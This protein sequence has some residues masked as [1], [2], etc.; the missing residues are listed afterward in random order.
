MLSIRDEGGLAAV[1]LKRLLQKIFA[2]CF[3]E[4]FD[5]FAYVLRALT[6]TDEQR[7]GSFHYDQ[8]L[9]ADRSDEFLRAVKEIAFSVDRLPAAVVRKNIFA[10][11]LCQQFI[12][13]RPGADIA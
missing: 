8:I 6:W 4:L 7:V 11:T 1:R 3:F 5:D 13:C 2:L 9:D 10:R 12:N